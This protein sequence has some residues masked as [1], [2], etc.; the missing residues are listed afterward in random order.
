VNAPVEWVFR[1]AG[2]CLI[3]TPDL[4]ARSSSACRWV[5]TMWPDPIVGWSQ[6]VWAP[7]ERGWSIPTTLMMG[8]VIEFGVT[9]YDAHGR[10]LPEATA[11]WYGWLDHATDYALIIH[12]PYVHP[13]DAV[14]AAR[15]TVNDLRLA[16]LDAPAVT[17]PSERVR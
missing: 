4:P 17:M 16:Q 11:R 3:D 5:A 6:L 9:V 1:Y 2:G 14:E 13:S 8:D 7:R 15:S 10:A 12:G